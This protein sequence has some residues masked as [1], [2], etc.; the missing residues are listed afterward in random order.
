[1]V[2]EGCAAAPET[3]TACGGAS[4][5]RTVA[6]ARARVAFSGSPFRDLRPAR[7]AAARTLTDLAASSLITVQGERWRG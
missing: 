1:M 3:P 4:T 7:P 2:D 5:H 6:G